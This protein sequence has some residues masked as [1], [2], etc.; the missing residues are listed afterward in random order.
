MAN[1]LVGLWLVPYLIGKL[2]VAGYGLVPLANQITNYAT[3]ITLAV[4]G[5][6]SRFLAIE[7]TRNDTL[8]ANQIFNTAFFSLALLLIALIPLTAVFSYFVPVLFDIPAQHVAG[9]QLLFLCIMGAFIVSTFRGNFAVSPFALNRL[10]IRNA[11]DLVNLLAR[12]GMIVLLFKVISV[13]LSQVG[14]AYLL[15]ALLAL[16][17]NVYSCK[18]LTPQLSVNRSYFDRSSLKELTSS[19]GWIV[20]NQIGA[21]LFLNIDLI[22]VNKL[23]GAA[24]AGSYSAILQWSSLLRMM[25]VTVAGAFTPIVIGYFAFNRRDKIIRFSQQTVKFTGLIMALPI[26]ALCG[27]SEPLLKIWL[28][29]DFIQFAPLLCLMLFHLPINL[30]VM[31]LFNINVASNM[32][33]TPGWV[34]LVMGMMNAFLAVALPL[35]LGW[36]VYGVAAAGAIVLTLKN[37]IFTP[38]YASRVLNTNSTAFNRA[39]LPAVVATALTAGSSYVINTVFIIAHW[40]SLAL[41]FAVITL[42]YLTAS[43][44]WAMNPS[45][46]HLLLSLLPQHSVV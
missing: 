46:R 29:P 38:W 22:V 25:G 39:M 31:P 9:S 45:E 23:F 40:W 33:K 16:G 18:K 5:S 32:V 12:V 35:A 26:G 24:S 10:D 42:V 34:T 37:A 15:S 8:K 4:N 21:L 30:G 44:R 43:W 20:V 27:F 2:G 19:G 7:I 13:S 3:L 28:G 1:V 17:L 36:G 14:L 6:V 41:A 11:I